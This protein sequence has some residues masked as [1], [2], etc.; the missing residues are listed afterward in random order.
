MRRFLLKM[1]IGTL[2][3]LGKLLCRVKFA[4]PLVRGIEAKLFEIRWRHSRSPGPAGGA[5]SHLF[6]TYEPQQTPK[7]IYC[8]IFSPERFKAGYFSQFGQDLFL[9]R[10]FFKDHRGGVFVD[11]G[12]FD[13]VTGSNTYFF[14]KQLGWR[15][16]AFEANPEVV[17]E[18]KRNR[19]CE[20]ID[21]CAY[22]RDGTVE[23]LTLTEAE[24]QAAKKPMQEPLNAASIV[25][26]SRHAG[27][28]LSGINS[29]LQE[30][31]RVAH[32]ERE[33]KLQRSTISVNCF[34]I[35]TVLQRAGIRVVD[36]LDI[37]VEG[38]EYE[39]LCGIDFHAVHYNVL[40]I[41]WN[42]RFPEV[43]ALLQEAG[44]EYQGLLMYDEVF[45]NRNLKYSWEQ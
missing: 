20:I 2:V 37:D 5:L 28:M 27:T 44:F 41:E 1:V 10:W 33:H 34:R 21:G 15:G 35:D 4:A 31:K 22:D 17:A 39:V 38:A 3:V 32:S 42:P 16:V 8:E 43:Y 19:T 18:L 14:E 11:V 36:F 45:I 12:A 25:F 23:F 13:G 6:K 26:D 24:Q 29:H 7:A 9:N 40:S 30:E